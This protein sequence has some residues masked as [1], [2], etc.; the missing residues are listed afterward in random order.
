MV[1]NE[2][3]KKLIESSIKEDRRIGMTLLLNKY[4]NIRYDY[5]NRSTRVIGVNTLKEILGELKF[6]PTVSGLIHP[7]DYE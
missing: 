5:F 2:S 7:E 6:K 3:I 1:D 4:P